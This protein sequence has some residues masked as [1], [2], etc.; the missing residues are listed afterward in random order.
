MKEPEIVIVIEGGTV[1]NVATAGSG[2]TYRIIDMDLIKV[3]DN[4]PAYTDNVPDVENAD[5]DRF[6]KDI[7]KDVL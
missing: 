1:A 6:T 3:G 5:I 7:L 4:E 2:I